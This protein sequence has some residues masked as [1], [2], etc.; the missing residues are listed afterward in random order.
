V[1]LDEFGQRV[2]E[3]AAEMSCGMLAFQDEVQVAEDLHPS[4]VTLPDGVVETALRTMT[5]LRT[6]P[7]D[8]AARAL[9]SRVPF[10]VQ[11]LAH[12][13]G[14]DWQFFVDMDSRH[15]GVPER[16]ADAVVCLALCNVADDRHRQAIEDISEFD[17][18]QARFHETLERIRAHVY[19]QTGLEL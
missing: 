14:D 6:Q 13:A 16:L 19:R 7:F 12:L 2:A 5:W 15:D 8:T 11:Q 17:R 18:L 4:F 3:Q 1:A 9:V 10:A